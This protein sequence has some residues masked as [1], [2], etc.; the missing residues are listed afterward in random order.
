[1]GS[2]C[3]T[4]STVQPMSRPIELTVEAIL[5]RSIPEP[6]S[7]C[8]IWLGN[9]G[10][11]TKNGKNHYGLIGQRHLKAH[12]VSYRVFKGR[13][14]YGKLVL[15]SCNNSLCVNPEHLRVGSDRDNQKDRYQSRLYGSV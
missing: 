6:N 12:R 13:I 2:A 4:E 11:R 10:S 8:W 14:P 3:F 1:M 15:H 9:I 5:D 7:G